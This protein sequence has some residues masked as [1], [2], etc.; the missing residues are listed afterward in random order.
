MHFAIIS[1]GE[2]GVGAITAAGQMPQACYTTPPL[3]RETENCDGDAT[4]YFS[5]NV[6]SKVE[7]IEL[8]DDILSYEDDS[9][10][11]IWTYSKAAGGNPADVVSSSSYVIGVNNDNPQYA[12]DVIGNVKIESGGGNAHT[13]RICDVDGANCF[14]PRVIS[15]ME[16]LM[17]CGAGD[18]VVTSI[19]A[20]TVVCAPNADIGGESLCPAG[21]YVTSIDSAGVVTCA[22]M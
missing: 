4:F 5:D 8:Y 14:F 10:T 16:P 17:N 6:Y 9:P 20:S 1:Y 2:N 13:G 19:S 3:P 22:P 12:L 11:R 15:G 7:G 18:A 21:E